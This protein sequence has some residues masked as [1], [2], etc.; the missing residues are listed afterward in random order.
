MVI[1]YAPSKFQEQNPNL[2]KEHSMSTHSS[3][4]QEEFPW[5][6]QEIRKSMTRQMKIDNFVARLMFAPRLTGNQVHRLPP[7]RAAHVIH[8]DRLP[9]APKDWV[10]SRGSY[11]V[12][13]DTE[14]GMWFDWRN[15]S[16]E[17]INIAVLPSVKGM[18]PLT[19]QKLDALRLEAYTEECPLHK[20][21][22][23][24]GG[25]LCEKCGWEW[26]PQ[27]YVTFDSTLWLD[28]YRIDGSVRQFFFSED[29]KRDIASLVIG[30][31]NTVPA[32]GFAFF[33]PKN[34]RM[35]PERILKRG[36]LD[37]M[38]WGSAGNDS[39]DMMVL[40]EGTDDTH[41]TWG[42]NSSTNTTDASF[43]QYL[44]NNSQTKSA[45]GHF[46]IKLSDGVPATPCAGMAYCCT[47]PTPTGTPQL[48][49]PPTQTLTPTPPD[50]RHKCGKQPRAAKSGRSK[51][52]SVSV[53]A[54]AE[55]DQK[56]QM[57]S[58]GV[59]GWQEEPAAIIRLYFVFQEQFQDIVAS[60][61]VAEL[62]GEKEGYLKGLPVG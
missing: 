42:A 15:G 29:D 45:L 8:L 18:N 6:T 55:I 28:G 41:T 49:P 44:V 37:S 61:G 32:F 36:M 39:L 5:L 58:L 16:A 14:I 51:I 30:K 11:V 31:D 52:A 46:E 33:R 13:V 47:T 19:G 7:G 1:K 62:E 12:P 59:E 60:G 27:S 38:Q 48:T 26:P 56:L 40:S 17:D 21:P 25:R 43:S 4:W 23:K 50:G 2:C 20:E 9:G 35:L 24:G 54:G 53:G 22:F 57:D 34:V 10:R 3:K